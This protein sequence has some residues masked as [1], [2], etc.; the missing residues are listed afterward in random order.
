MTDA[1]RFL[2]KPMKPG[3]QWI[4]CLLEDLERQ[5]ID[6]GDIACFHRILKLPDV[7]DNADKALRI[8]KQAETDAERIILPLAH[9][10]F[11]G[12]EYYPLTLVEYASLLDT[13][14]RTMLVY[15]MMTMPADG[16]QGRHPINEPSIDRLI[17]LWRIQHKERIVERGEFIR[18]FAEMSQLLTC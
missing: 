6:T 11:H 9:P 4:P 10:R 3:S 1:Y 5:K 2:I 17:G 16:Q 14:P 18:L 15:D 12:D 8:F 7:N 13:D